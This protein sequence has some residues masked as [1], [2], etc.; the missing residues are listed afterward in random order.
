M[1]V[2][3]TTSEGFSV[4][5]ALDHLRHYLPSQAPLKDFIH[6]N[7]LHAFQA[8]PF[9]SALIDAAELYGAVCFL[10]IQDYRTFWAQ[11]RMTESGILSAVQRYPKLSDSADELRAILRGDRDYPNPQ[12]SGNQTLR[13]Q[14][15]DRLGFELDLKVRSLLFRLTA[16][17][18][19][20][21]IASWIFLDSDKKSFFECVQEIS[22]V[23]LPPLPPLSDSWIQRWMQSGPEQVILKVLERFV[24]EE[25]HFEHYLQETLLAHP[26][27]SGMVS[28]VESQPEGLSHGRSISL[29]E[30]TAV[31]LLIEY[32]LVVR[33]LGHDFEPLSVSELEQ[34]NSQKIAPQLDPVLLLAQRTLEESYYERTIKTVLT[35]QPRANRTSIW[36]QAIFCIDDRE[37]SI[38]RHLESLDS[39]IETFGAAG[40]FGV[41]AMVQR[42]GELKPFK[43][44]PLPV[45]PQ[46]L[47]RYQ[48]EPGKIGATR[49]EDLDWMKSIHG[50][51]SKDVLTGLSSLP[52][53]GLKSFLR[54][55]FDV[56]SP[57]AHAEAYGLNRLIPSGKLELLHRGQRTPDGKLQIGYTIEEMATRV[58][59]LLRQIGLTAHFAPLVH[60]IG[61]GSSSTNNPYFSAYDCGACS[62]KPGITNA[63]AFAEMANMPEVRKLLKVQYQ[64]SI[65][66]NTFFVSALHDTCRDTVDY[67]IDD[68][69]LAAEKIDSAF[70]K[71][72]GILDA[73][74]IQN[75]V[76]R[77]QKFELAPDPLEPS[78]AHRHVMD[79]SRSIFEPRPELNHATNAAC[80]VGRRILT[81][82]TSLE[83]RSFL[84]SYDFAQDPDG[85]ILNAILTAIVPVCGGINLEYYFS[86]IDPEIYGAGTKISHNVVGLL[87]VFNGSEGDLLTGLPTQMTEMH[88]P[89]RLVFIIEQSRGVVEKVIASNA[90][91]AE[92]FQGG[93]LELVV[94]E[95]TPQKNAYRWVEGRFELW[96]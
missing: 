40:F 8:E 17:F 33:H 86:R 1:A 64:I 43:S 73:A 36:T 53:L 30:F 32:G 27:W 88:D 52:S 93:W 46:H 49:T 2:R 80:V 62:G 48:D 51:S 23:K 83:R 47:I 58:A 82:G 31:K 37:C 72:R 74:L 38:R 5:A 55:V 77:C 10:P 9:E 75:A 34:K 79:R 96:K 21:G 59:N 20:Q 12:R 18:L 78:S 45:Q 4:Q 28:V 15:R 25:R 6:H 68:S 35:H 65:P 14:W 19:D 95:P 11:G 41:D 67:L 50:S 61:H 63:R 84:Q 42:Q 85:R 3:L 91:V 69:L 76:E 22:A 16:N 60:V 92:W 89:I 87:G 44:C 66:E 81:S 57:V 56:F 94:I 13:S 54:L 70:E 24:A 26:G 7:T 39:G 71:F 90:A 29:I